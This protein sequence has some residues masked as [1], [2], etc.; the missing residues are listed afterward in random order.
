MKKLKTFKRM[1]SKATAMLLCLATSATCLTFAAPFVAGASAATDNINQ[2]AATIAD[3]VNIPESCDYGSTFTVPEGAVVTAPNGE[4]VSGTS[5]SANQ[6]GNYKV[7]FASGELDYT[8][9][10]KVRLN[11]EYFLKVD[12]N[13]ADIP[14]YLKTGEGKFNLPNAGVYYYDDNNIL[15]AYPGDV[16]VSIKDSLGK[17]YSPNDEYTANNTTGKVFFTY[18]ATVGNEGTKHFSQTFTVNVQSEVPGGTGNPTL[19]VSG[20]QRDVSINRAV[21]LPKATAT[22]SYDDN[23]KVTVQVLDPDGNAVKYVDVDED[24]YAVVKENADPVIFDNDKAMTFYPTKTGTYTV[25]YNAENDKGG[26]ASEKVY[27]MTVSDLVAPVF[28]NVEEWRI[29]ETWGVTVKSETNENVDNTITFSIPDVVDNKDGKEG[30]DPIKMY[31]RITDSDNSKTIVEFSNILAEKDSADAQFT[32]NDTYGSDGD[33]GNKI[34]FNKNS[35]NAAERV[36]KFDFGKYNKVN[37]KGEKQA[38]PGTYTV[39]YRARDNANNTSSRTFTITL[40]EEYEDKVAPTTTE[41]TVPDY[42]SAA[43]KTF[44]VPQAT[45][46][47]AMDTRLKKDY[48]IYNENGDAIEVVGGEEADIKSVGG[49]LS[50]VIDDDEQNALE[51]TNKLYFYVAATDKVGNFRSNVEKKGD[52]GK[53]EYVELGFGDSNKPSKETLENCVAKVTVVQSAN[54]A[55]MGFDDTNMTYDEAA[56]IKDTDGNIKAGSSVVYG[57]FAITT[58]EAMRNYTGFEVAAYDP[59]GNVLNVTLETMSTVKDDVAKIIV[60]NIRFNLPTAAE[61]NQYKLIIRLF[62]VHGYNRIFGY[63]FDKEV[64]SSGNSNIGTQGISTI[65][66]S[67]EVAVSYKL[68]N[69]VIK[70]INGQEGDVYRVV[71]RISGGVFSLMGSEFTAKTQGSYT[72]FDGYIKEGDANDEDIGYVSGDNEFIYD[73]AIPA[74][75]NNGV[76]NFNITDTAAPVIEVQGVMPTYVAFPE[77]Q[78]GDNVAVKSVNVNLPAIVAYTENGDA[79]VKIEVTGPKNGKSVDVKDSDDGSKYFTATED[80]AYTV[81]VTAT[82]ANATPATATYTVNVGDVQ[83][84]EFK[85][86]YATDSTTLGKTYTVGQIFKFAQMELLENESGVEITKTLVN[87]SK[88]NVADA[89]IT[90]SYDNNKDRLDNNTDIKFDMAGTY[91]VV[92]T[93]KDTYGNETKQEYE[94]TVVSSGTSTPTTWTTLSTVLIIVAVVLLAGVIVYVV[95][96]RKVKK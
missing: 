57:G 73:K 68:H 64:V 33:K 81:K 67:G 36:F 65:G 91:K 53:T 71:R 86:N 28:K 17:T 6:I 75:G 69:D 63:T 22:D 9:Y 15:T 41:V 95:R 94:I 70:G 56:F 93:A 96:F 20:V 40:K 88:E 23:V 21:T 10:V 58:T 14:S 77:K 66:A 42:I 60:Q 44:T 49:K 34:T 24:G 29:P 47:D 83:G 43:D 55:I 54:E 25:K 16:S 87:P 80:G 74:G 62:D 89:V 76:Y 26:K 27:Y 7:K 30:G 78:E 51:L 8:F 32:Y 13:G 5:I 92:Y 84:P 50:L 48:R 38:L 85:L 59:N 1:S 45:V 82:Y 2:G 52:N 11:K 3:N 18:N 31:F 19:S 37:A 12:Y 46:A 72:V 61:A 35:D 4:T 90:G 39:L 79:E